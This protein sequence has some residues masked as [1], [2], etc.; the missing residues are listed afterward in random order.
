MAAPY[1]ISLAAPSS[2]QLGRPINA[3]AHPWPVA[4]DQFGRPR[5][6]QLGRPHAHA[7]H[8]PQALGRD[9]LGRPR[10][11]QLGR[12]RRDQFRCLHTDQLAHH[13]GRRPS[14][15][16]R[17]R[18]TRASPRQVDPPR[19]SDRPSIPCARAQAPAR[20]PAAAKQ[21][22]ASRSSV[23]FRRSFIGS[24]SE[25]MSLPAGPPGVIPVSLMAHA[26]T[27]PGVQRAR[28]GGG[29][30]PG[31]GRRRL[32]CG[33]A[34]ADPPGA[35]LSLPPTVFLNRIRVA[36]RAARRCRHTSMC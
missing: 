34:A 19:V 2:D 4:P 18:R 7:R 28:G 25:P 27:V 17:G 3:H 8:P 13:R 21:R 22:R 32:R 23:I 24:S 33:D 31:R 11:D 9:Q 15:R 14:R 16:P 29:R 26:A 30:G 36:P 1:A 10:C 5:R 35:A 12:P 6:D 20:S